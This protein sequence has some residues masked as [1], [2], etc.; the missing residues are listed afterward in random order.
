MQAMISQIN[1]EKFIAFSFR[2]E[3]LKG[4]VREMEW[5]VQVKFS[6][7]LPTSENEK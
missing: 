2:I 3:G 1:D 6:I 7:C 4:S 5:S